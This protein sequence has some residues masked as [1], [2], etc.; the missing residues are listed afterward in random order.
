MTETLGP[1]GA[2]SENLYSQSGPRP[3]QATLKKWKTEAEEAEEN[4]CGERSLNG[5]RPSNRMGLRQEDSEFKALE[6]DSTPGYPGDG[7]PRVSELGSMERCNDCDLTPWRVSRGG[8]AGKCQRCK[9]V[10]KR[11]TEMVKCR[12]CAWRV[13]ATCHNLETRG[14]FAPPLPEITHLDHADHDDEMPDQK[15]TAEDDEMLRDHSRSA[16]LNRKP[17]SKGTQETT[18]GRG[19]KKHELQAIGGQR[20]SLPQESEQNNIQ[21]K[22]RMPESCETDHVGEHTSYSRR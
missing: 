17:D 8:S 7:P 4:N 18:G 14:E 22:Q 11:G 1:T 20:A 21:S 3:L 15:D 6:F 5:S 16:G 9:H 13:C 19:K 2:I 12:V 10:R